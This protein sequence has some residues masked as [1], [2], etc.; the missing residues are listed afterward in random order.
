MLR[1][2]LAIAFKELRLWLQ[3][4]GNWLV[5]FLVPFAFIGI[6]GSVSSRVPRWLP[7]MR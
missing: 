5:V 7:S 2:I 6:F 4:P 1:K 3:M